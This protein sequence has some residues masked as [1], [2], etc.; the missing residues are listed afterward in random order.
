MRTE[1]ATRHFIK[2]PQYPSLVLIGVFMFVVT[3]MA[4]PF[5]SVR[6]TSLPIS[7]ASQ[8]S[9][10]SVGY[11]KAGW[12]RSLTVLKPAVFAARSVESGSLLP[13]PA[14]SPETINTF[15]SDCTTPKTSFILGETVCAQTDNVTETNRF[16]NWC[17]SCPTIDYGGPTT[18]AITTNPQNFL[19]TPTKTGT[20]KAT[21]ADPNDSSIIPTV[22]T[23]DPAPPPSGPE[24]I[25]TY[26]ANCTTAANLFT[27][28]DTVW[29]R[30]SNS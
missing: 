4:V 21:I 3:A 25:A 6:S 17:V 20:W 5:Y 12:V 14:P 19:Y 26:Q 15:A 9:V 22:F 24:T 30:I 10:P 8:A 27:T 1:N 28:G 2:R 7:S 13:L 11:A 18:T 29:V 23:V 16:V